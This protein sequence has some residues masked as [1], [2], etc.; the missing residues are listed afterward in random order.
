MCIF[1]ATS[2]AW[3]PALVAL[4]HPDDDHLHVVCT[5][6]DG[7]GTPGCVP[8]TFRVPRPLIFRHDG[9]ALHLRAG[10]EAQMLISD[11]LGY[12]CHV[13]A[14][15]VV[16]KVWNEGFAIVTI[17]SQCR[18]VIAQK[19]MAVVLAT[20]RALPYLLS[21]L[22]SERLDGPD[23]P[24]PVIFVSGLRNRTFGSQIQ[25]SHPLLQR[26]ERV[27]FFSNT[28]PYWRHRSGLV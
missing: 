3:L 4:D 5:V 7:T 20:V 18:D 9:Q 28:W 1:L 10:E 17:C 26:K 15:V 16:K 12:K 8:P 22:P 27:H 11:G 14:K 6:E 2:L 13:W 25:L 23:A 19:V 21:G 24:R